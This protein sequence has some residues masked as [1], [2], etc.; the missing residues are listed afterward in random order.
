MYFQFNKRFLNSYR[1][2]FI[3]INLAQTLGYTDNKKPKFITTTHPKDSLI[4]LM[5]YLSCL[6]QCLP[7]NMS[8]R[9]F[10]KEMNAWILNLMHF[11]STPLSLLMP[12]FHEY[13]HAVYVDFHTFSS[14]LI[15]YKTY[16]FGS[17]SSLNHC[18]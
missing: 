17:Q 13:V 9:L 7:Q 6:E 14:Y 18:L 12:I 11:S 5:Q 15:L 1:I 3:N 4:L 10:S 8:F 2:L 16:S